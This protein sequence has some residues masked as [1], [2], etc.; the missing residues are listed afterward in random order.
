M[1]NLLSALVWVLFGLLS[2]SVRADIR[3]V[4]PQKPTADRTKS[5][6]EARHAQCLQLA[7]NG[8]APVVFLGDSITHFWESNGHAQWKKYFAEGPRRAINLGFSGDRTEHVLW[9]LDNGELSGYEAKVIVLMI[10]TNNTGHFTEEEEPPL[11]TILGIRAVLDKIREKQPRAKIV[12]CSIFPRGA[13]VKD[14][15]RVRNRVVN[16][17][18]MRFADGRNVFWC[19][20]SSQFLMPDGRLPA[21]IFPDHLHPAAHGYEVWTSAVMPYID[22]ALAPEPVPPPPNRQEYFAG[23]DAFKGIDPVP[24][25]AISL[26]GRREWWWKD[27]EMWLNAVRRHRRE[28]SELGPEIDLVFLGDSITRGWEGNGKKVLEE[29]RRTYRIHTLGIGGD[30]VQH[31]IW[32]AR[33]GELAGYRA[34][35]VMIMIGTNNNYGDKPNATAVGIKRLLAE[36]RAH[37]PQAKILLVPVFPREERPDAAKRLNNAAVN[38]IIRAY[39]DDRDVFWLDFNDRLV[40]ADGTISR[41]LMPDFLHPVEAGYRIWADAALPYFRRFCGK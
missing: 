38:K 9:R 29:L 6:W 12:L 13:D 28:A 4:T 1:K 7:K 41:E 37:Q 30:R 39:A 10:G 24:A 23:P 20:F 15:C 26:I 21:E 18:V 19:D 8:G 14:A 27:P 34:K 5:W 31:N 25:Q 3:S 11:D 40:Q 22:Y 36:V 32:R 17:E 16:D 33:Y 2:I 35:C